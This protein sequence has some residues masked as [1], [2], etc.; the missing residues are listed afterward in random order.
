[1]TFGA[2]RL[3]TLSAAASGP[4]GRGIT[5][6][7]VG[8]AQISTTS[9]KFGGASFRSDGNGDVIYTSDIPNIAMSGDFTI[10]L[11]FN[12]DSLTRAQY[13]IGNR[14][15][16]S[17]I[18]GDWTFWHS[19]SGSQLQVAS[20]NWKTIPVNASGNYTAA[21]WNHLAVVRSG[22]TVTAYIN[23]VSKGTATSSATLCATNKKLVIGSYDQTG[24]TTD[25]MLGYIDEVRVSNIARYTANFTS[26]TAQFVNDANTLFLLHANGTNG[27]TVFVDDSA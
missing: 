22:T 4:A 13:L 21:T 19:P 23:G 2:F 8:N 20:P 15:S 17:Y 18:S 12:A 1:M 3:N 16:G 11:W 7:P 9:S 10:E 25:S 27:S 26:P 14:W 5:I 6:T 24:A